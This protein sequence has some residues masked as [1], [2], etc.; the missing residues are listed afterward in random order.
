[1]NITFAPG[2]ILQIDNARITYKNFAGVGNK[3]NREGDRNFALVI[4]PGYV[5]KDPVLKSAEEI[6]DI[7][8]A[9]VNKYGV[10][11][12]VKTKPPRDEDGDPFIYMPVKLKIT[13]RTSVY[14]R[15]GDN[16]IDLD[17]ESVAMLD[18]IDIMNVDLDIR[19]YDDT[20]VSGP[21]RAAYV[22]SMCVTQDID[23]F[24][25]RYE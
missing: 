3:F 10:G 22:R 5:D 23:R 20:M 2:G 16:M 15:T 19:P 1:M 12:N 8:K 11:W 9:D 6:R 18:N 7:L 14:L 17:E 13:D 24:K 4:E 21:F 25:A